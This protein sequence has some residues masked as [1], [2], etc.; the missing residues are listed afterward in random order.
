MAYVSLT[1]F[2]EDGS[3]QTYHVFKSEESLL[4]HIKRHL[5]E[6]RAIIILK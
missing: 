4:N 1:V 3:L 6:A 5:E 2:D